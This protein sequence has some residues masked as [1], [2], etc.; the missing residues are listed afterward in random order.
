[1]STVEDFKNAPVGA[2]A[3][4][5]TMGIRVM[6]VNDGDQYWIVQ[7]G[8][9]LS[10]E[11]VALRDFALDLLAPST[12]REAL[13]I[14]WELAHEVKPGQVIPEGNQ[15][16][17]VTQFGLKEYTAQRDSELA[18][19]YVPVV[20]TVEPLPEPKPDWIDAP[21]VLAETSMCPDRKVWVPESG[22]VWKCSCC[23][24]ELHWCD[25]VDV[26]PLY[27]KGQEK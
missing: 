23:R 20:R 12:A 3:T 7:S 18:L 11:E 1:M 27:P 13:D 15:Y 17:E 10:D 16:L 9:Y 24:D 26:T 5:K 22:G 14:A 8:G 25:L 6:K 21:A 4:H 19:S 2:T